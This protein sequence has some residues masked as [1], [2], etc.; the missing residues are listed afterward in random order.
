MHSMTAAMLMTNTLTQRNSPSAAYDKRGNPVSHTA[1]QGIFAIACK[2]RIS[3][4]NYEI[5]ST[6]SAV[7][8]HPLVGSHSNS[9]A[10]VFIHEAIL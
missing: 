6:S 4:N 9:L 10:F 8:L 5:I 2:G 7:E 3:A 1:C